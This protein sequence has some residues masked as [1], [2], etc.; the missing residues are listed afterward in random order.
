MSPSQTNRSAQR[1]AISGVNTA[2]L[3]PL[4]PEPGTGA[5]WPLE[6]APM[7]GCVA[8]VPPKVSG[9]FGSTHSG[10]DS[11]RPARPS[12]SAAELAAAT[13]L[14]LLPPSVGTTSGRPVESVEVDS[15]HH[16]A[17]L[18]RKASGGRNRLRLICEMSWPLAVNRDPAPV[19]WAVVVPVAWVT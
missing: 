11:M 13:W 10:S 19:N 15:A 1:A 16:T 9:M 17:G 7:D 14:K 3:P 4:P 8:P 6:T 2:A 12:D 5:V 18:A